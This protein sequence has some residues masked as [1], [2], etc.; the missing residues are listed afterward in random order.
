MPQ[1]TP[2]VGRALKHMYLLYV[3]IIDKKMRAYDLT[4]AQSDLLCQLAKENGQTQA[5]LSDRLGISPPTLSTSADALEK[6]G[7]IER[8]SSHRDARQKLLYLTEKGTI[9]IPNILEANSE[10]QE[11][12]TTDLSLA[13]QTLLAEWIQAMHQKL[14]AESQKINP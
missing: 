1:D 13:E 6:K 5:E 3:K 7:F 12:I 8:R 9:L 4:Y 2:Q 11:A 10:V 14:Q